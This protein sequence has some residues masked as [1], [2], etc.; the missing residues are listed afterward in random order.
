MNQ[1]TSYNPSS[2]ETVTEDPINVTFDW[3]PTI[4]DGCARFRLRLERTGR[5]SIIN[6]EL[7]LARCTENELVRLNQ[8][9]VRQHLDA[10]THEEMA[11]SIYWL[12]DCS[13]RQAEPTLNAGARR[14]KLR[15]F[16]LC[17]ESPAVTLRR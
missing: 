7:N 2:P 12:V 15:A 3:E 6:F 17:E 14:A 13:L 9:L 1:P 4:K 5:R 8:F 10:T 11:A 16:L